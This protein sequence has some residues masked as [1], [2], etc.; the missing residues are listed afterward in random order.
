MAKPKQLTVG[1]KVRML[2]TMTYSLSILMVRRLLFLIVACLFGIVALGSNRPLAVLAQSP[3]PEPRPQPVWDGTLRRIRVPILMYHYV[4][5]LPADAD[6]YRVDL[7]IIPE[8][9]RAH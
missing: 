2:G 6:Q 9:F 8:L 4:S 1:R 3:D 7:T 5:N